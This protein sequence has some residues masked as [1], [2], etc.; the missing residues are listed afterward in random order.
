MPMDFLVWPDEHDGHFEVCYDAD[1]PRG[2]LCSWCQG[3]LEKLERTVRQERR[4]RRR[5]TGLRAVK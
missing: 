2:E 5:R 1:A 3:E 4:R